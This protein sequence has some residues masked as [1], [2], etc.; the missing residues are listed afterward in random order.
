[1]FVISNGCLVAQST[2]PADSL[3]AIHYEIHIDT[4]N[5]QAHSIGASATV[6]LTPLNGPV[7]SI[8]LELINLTVTAAWLNGVPVSDFIQSDSLI[9]IFPSITLFPGDT[10]NVRFDYQGVPFH[11]SWGGF[12]FAGEYAFNLGVGISMIPH[13]LGKSW[14]PCVDNFTDRA[15]YD[16]YCTLPAGKIAVGGGLLTEQIDN[17]NGLTTYHWNLAQPVPT[18]L[19]SLAV[20]N[21]APVNDTFTGINGQVPINIY[22]RLQDTSK[23]AGTF[24]HLKQILAIF[25]DCLGPYSWDRIGYTATNLGAMEHATNIFVPYNT[26]NGNTGY[27]SLMAHELTHMWMGDNV[28]C[29]S[30]EEMWINEGWATFFQMYYRIPLYGDEAGFTQNMR[31]THSDVLQFCHTPYG[32]GSYFPMNRIPQE[33]TY[34]HWSSYDRGSTIVQALR[35]YLGDSLF[36]E[37]VKAFIGEYEFS[38]V[39]SYDMRDFMSEYTGFDMGGFFDNFVLHSGVPHYSVDSFA[40]GMNRK[41]LYDVTVFVKQKRK[42]PAFTGNHNIVEVM[43]MDEEW[44]RFTDTIHFSGQTGHSVKM[45][46][47]IP[48]VI[49][50]DPGEKMY[51]ATTDNFKTIKTTGDY[52]FDKTFFTLNVESISDSA[53]VQA[54]HNWAPPD[55][56]KEPVAGLR[57]SDYRYWTINGIFP[58]DFQASGTFFYTTDGYLDDSLILSESDTAVILYRVSAHEDWQ[59]IEF[60]KVG[61]WFIGNIKVHNLRPGEYTLAVKEAGVGSQEPCLPKK[62]GIEIY[63]NPSAGHFTI[64]SRSQ[65]GGAIHIFNESGKKVGEFP[66]KAGEE[67]HTWLPQGLSSG[68]YFIALYEKGEAHPVVNKVFFMD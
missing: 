6:T 35:F 48:S 49:L 11:E 45:A 26:I 29:S 13:N 51:D 3:D 64:L 44:N 46:P 18:Y 57:L 5:F 21:Y 9:S 37:T 61:P 50:M 58:E 10:V 60:D 43:F 2:S 15:T 68:M 22:V 19:S 56:L 33:Y 40:V 47:F 1:M 34:S 62:N 53:F 42:G 38:P 55:S 20:G 17:G 67:Q 39:S 28:T 31:T 54:T 63:P 16:V 12:H 8:D 14:Y 65:N 30:A 24:V 27:E 52:A 66:V 32:N 4:I 59:E 41:D 23:V 36:F 25:E 7:A